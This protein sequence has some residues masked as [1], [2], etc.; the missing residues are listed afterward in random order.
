MS[1]ALSLL[2]GAAFVVWSAPLMLDRLIRLPVEPQTTLVTWVV[3]VSSTFLTSVAALIVLLLPG[4][5][6]VRWILE[7]AH[8]CWFALGHD[9]LP[10]LD[11]IAGIFGIVLAA[12]A[13]TRVSWNVVRHVRRQRS[14]Y[15]QQVDLLRFVAHPEPGRYPT[16]W[17]DHPE[18]MSY[19]IAGAQALIVATRGLG[20]NL[21]PRGVAAV[22]EHERAHLRGRHHQ[23]VGF[24]Q[25][26]AAALP[27]L[28]LTRHAPGF[29]RTCVELAADSAAVR[30]HGADAVR[31]ALVSM[32]RG[33][34]PGP[35]LGMADESVKL[36]LDR[37]DYSRGPG[38]LRR[39]VGSGLAGLTAVF[40]PLAVSAVLLGTAVAMSCALLV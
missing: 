7:L 22:L 40:L 35:A 30:A 31:S 11:A 36:R 2:L 20:E 28:P 23:L 14:V 12:G 19:S 37:L 15:R 8:R 10:Q 39:T 26:L 9:P 21:S 24:A 5:G 38:P 27:W 18:P 1:V 17:L 29:I 3:L 16:M 34:V 25:S 32:S 13:V 6:P 4:H 33:A